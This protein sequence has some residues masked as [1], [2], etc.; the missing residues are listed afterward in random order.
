M[1]Q[2]KLLFLLSYY[3]FLQFQNIQAIPLL[4]KVTF[5]YINYIKQLDL[6]ILIYYNMDFSRNL[7]SYLKHRKQYFTVDGNTVL[8]RISKPIQIII[9]QN[10]NN[11]IFKYIDLSISVILLF[12]PMHFSCMM[13]RLLPRYTFNSILYLQ[14]IINYIGL[15]YKV[16]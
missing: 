3:S 10:L 13:I 2:D 7:L 11:N 4:E 16:G 15:S 8:I 9:L 12:H 6:T 14:Y 1:K 5:F